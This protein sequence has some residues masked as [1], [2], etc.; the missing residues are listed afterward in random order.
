MEE[1]TAG[2]F[3][4]LIADVLVVAV[5]YRGKVEV[6][7][8]IENLRVSTDIFYYTKKCCRCRKIQLRYVG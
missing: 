4:A 5:E 2:E 1:L 3:R 7:T 8:L 6:E